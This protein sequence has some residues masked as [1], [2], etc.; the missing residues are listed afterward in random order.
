MKIAVIGAG[1][2]GCYISE[3]LIKNGYDVSIFE[4]NSDIFSNASLNN[5]NRLHYGFHYPRSYKTMQQ[6]K[7]GFHEFKNI[8]S[9][10][11]K[12]I[13]KNYYLISSDNDSK[14]NFKKYCLKLKTA[15]INFSKISIN[16]YSY[17]NKNKIESGIASNEE[18]ILAKKAKR[19]FKNI[20]KNNI[21][22]NFEIKKI[23][24]KDKKYQI[25]KKKFDFVINCTWLQFSNQSVNN[26]IFEYCTILKYKS[27]IKNHPSTTIMDGPFFTLYPWD[28]Y[29]NFGLYSV[30]MSRLMIGKNYNLLK[31]K[32]DLKITKKF[33]NDVRDKIESDFLDY[34]PDFKKNFK[35][36]GYLNSFRTI[37]KNKN[38]ARI[39]Y[40][41]EKNNFINVFSGKIDHI[42]YAYKEVEKCIKN[43]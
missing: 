43:Y 5:Q 15:K 32:V 17:L 9:N 31:K 21:N 6:C 8:F 7:N 27:K 10:F 29:N 33:L 22:F 2:F 41:N 30:S 37:I 40:V 34:Y 12:S 14:L 4:K 11:T 13:N 3:Q 23:F 28:E 18:L 19:Y 38:D 36:M 16:D 24:Y 35:F 1:W 25:K 39:C 42:F 20:L 26:L